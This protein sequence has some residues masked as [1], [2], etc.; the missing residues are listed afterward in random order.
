MFLVNTLLTCPKYRPFTRTQARQA[1]AAT[2]QMVQLTKMP[3][4]PPLSATSVAPAASQP[5]APQKPDK[6]APGPNQ[7]NISNVPLQL[8]KQFSLMGSLRCTQFPAWRKTLSFK[9]KNRAVLQQMLQQG[10]TPTKRLV[11]NL[12]SISQPFNPPL[13]FHHVG[14]CYNPSVKNFQ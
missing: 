1:V 8:H 11:K 3:P 5:Q 9:C 12:Q 13:K 6:G 10:Y 4:T 7:P 14:L 2:A